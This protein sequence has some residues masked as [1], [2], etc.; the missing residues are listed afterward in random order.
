M[1][2]AWASEPQYLA[3]LEPI[4][5][6]MPEGLRGTLYA[7]SRLAIQLAGAGLDARLRPPE[8]RGGPILV[9]SWSDYS[10]TGNRPV[11]FLEHGAG[12]TYS[13]QDRCNPGGRGRERVVLF[14][15][16]NSRTAALDHAAYPDAAV[17]IVGCPRLDD[18]A[19][20]PCP[21][22]GV[23]VSW[24]W[25][26][27]QCPESRSAWSYYQGA[28]AELAG[29]RP[30][31]GHAH[32]RMWPRASRIYRRIGIE[33][34]ADFAEVVRR[35]RVYVCDNS[36]TLFEWAAL[37]RPCVVLNAPWYRRDVE[38]G[39]RFWEWAGIGINV[40]DPADLADAIREAEQ[41]TPEQHNIRLAASSEIYP[42]RGG[43]MR[44]VQAM[45]RVCGR[46]A[47][48]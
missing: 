43:A 4:W 10:M 1:I 24:H 11:I 12:Q 20:I 21:A 5:R 8:R 44:A 6:A 7:S 34:V 23:A 33:P 41:D 37:D 22:D 2:D 17:E 48:V 46:Y 13:D 9:A 38:H 19:L 3:H 40:D 27:R 42:V 45:E 31:I 18:L 26:N 29:F 16:T 30:L 15:A 32:P 28:V 36:S 25:E 14:L 47:T 39:L 35:A